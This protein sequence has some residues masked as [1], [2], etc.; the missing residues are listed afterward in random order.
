M[1][2]PRPRED[3]DSAE[4]CS[5]VE[6]LQHTCPVEEVNGVQK[7]VCYPI[8]RIFRVC[9]GLWFIAVRAPDLLAIS[10]CEGK[11]TVELTR[12]VRIDMSTGQVELSRG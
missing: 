5:L 10:R 7:Y 8:P 1:S 2:G 3:K 11:P 12:F 4:R 6:L 9:V